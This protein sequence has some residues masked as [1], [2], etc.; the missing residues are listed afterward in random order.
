[1]PAVKAEDASDAARRAHQTHELAD[2]RRLSSP[3]RAEKAEDLT[4]LHLEGKV[5][6]AT[7]LAVV[8]GQPFDL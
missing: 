6:D 8:T 5:H 1:M 2:G 7:S 4:L 3:V